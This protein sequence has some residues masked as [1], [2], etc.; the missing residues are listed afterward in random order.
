MPLRR[1]SVEAI[2]PNFS[3]TEWVAKVLR[4]RILKSVYRPG[5]RI[6]EAQLQAEF[7]LSN[8]PIREALH[9]IVSEGLAERIPAKGVRVVQLGKREIAD[10][11]QLRL[12]LLEHAAELAARKSDTIDPDE[13]AS[14]KKTLKT[15]LS[16][17][18]DGNLALMNGELVQWILKV[19]DNKPITDVWNKTMLQT[20]VYVYEAMLRSAAKSE[21]IQFDI[22]V[23]IMR[24]DV[25]SAR[26]ATRQLTRQTL[27]DLNIQTSL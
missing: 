20:R 26:R 4:D 12:A 10:L 17:V 1:A 8:G 21:G 18:R 15:A 23:A 25:E 14:L 27:F 11:F 24:G 9:L 5:D 7:N 19:A 6:I 2:V 22:I 3:R 16:G 13:V